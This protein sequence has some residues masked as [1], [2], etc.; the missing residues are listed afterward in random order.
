M[1]RSEKAGFKGN[2]S[3]L[4]SKTWLVCGKET[5]PGAS[6]G[7]KI[8][9]KLNIA[10][11]PVALKNRYQDWGLN[12][13]LIYWFRNDLRL[14][15]KSAFARA[16]L[17][18]DHLLPVYI[19]DSKEQDAIYGFE[20]QGLHRKTFLRASLDDLKTQLQVEGP[21]L[22]SFWQAITSIVAV[23]QRHCCQC[24]LLR[25]NWSPWRNWASQHAAEQ[26]T[27]VNEFWQSSMLDPQFVF[28]LPWKMPDVFTAF[29]REVERAQLKFA[30]PIST[31]KH[32][33]PLPKVLPQG[34]IK[35]DIHC[36]IIGSPLF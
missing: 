3:F 16:C 9:M 20:R 24:N 36:C 5:N 13:I 30:Q 25:E 8:G 31:P 21:D 14:A 29:R 23:T 28:H 22:L 4:P 18:A 6:S 26:G 15:D 2:K 27:D 1:S 12:E 35:R 11:M 7:L 34:T 19:H 32:I 17:N 33:P 10:R